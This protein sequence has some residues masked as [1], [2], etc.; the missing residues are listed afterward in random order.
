[1]SKKGLLIHLILSIILILIVIF[2]CAE[3]KI[4]I[5]VVFSLIEIL[6]TT[7]V[8]NS[9]DVNLD[10]TIQ[11]NFDESVMRSD[12]EILLVNGRTSTS[13]ATDD[14]QIIYQNENSNVNITLPSQLFPNTIYTVMLDQGAFTNDN[15]QETEAITFYITSKRLI[16]INI[17]SNIPNDHA[18][19]VNFD[20]TIQINFDDSI[21]RSDGEILLVNNSNFI[22]TPIAIDD[23]QIIYQN[24]NSSVIITLPIL[25]IQN[26]MY[27]VNLA[28]GSF[29][30]EK[31]AEN[32]AK[33]FSFTTS[34]TQNLSS[35]LTATESTFF[36]A[37]ANNGSFET[38]LRIRLENTN[39]V[40]ITAF[41]RPPSR[42]VF[43]TDLGNRAVGAV[44]D[45]GVPVPVGI[46]NLP[47]GL[48][49]NLTIEKV[50]DSDAIDILV[51]LNGNSD[52]HAETIDNTN[53]TLF[54]DEALFNTLD[55]HRYTV[56]DISFEYDIIFGDF[57][58]P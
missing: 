29:T 55:V 35:I 38:S 32:L 9:T 18:T 39:L 25:L 48:M 52:S 46:N 10:T 36:E 34:D 22:S 20:T 12:G 47:P 2:S 5:P 3:K 58:T 40:E 51:T 28:R 41:F 8:N 4:H 11:I 42:V 17:L 54:F 1:M 19:D 13:I 6:S 14:S 16:P 45:D 23:S 24:E 44:G 49:V 21:M 33:S 15:N 7:P 26:T 37:V 57:S 27:T 31:N 53:F 50:T 56:Q 30:N 43:D